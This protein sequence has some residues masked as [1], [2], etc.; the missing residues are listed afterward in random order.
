LRAT[1]PWSSAG[2]A[3]D[4]I[5]RH[6]TWDYDQQTWLCSFCELRDRSEG[7]REVMQN[8]SLLLG[9]GIGLFGALAVLTARY[10]AVVLMG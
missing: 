9:V 3:I 10:V 7:E 5:R 6:H 1:Q 8:R 4:L 2:F